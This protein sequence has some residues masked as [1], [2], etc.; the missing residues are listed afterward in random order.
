MKQKSGEKSK[1]NMQKQKT[2]RDKNVV[3]IKLEKLDRDNF[4]LCCVS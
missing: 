2:N 4:R 1:Q 3:W